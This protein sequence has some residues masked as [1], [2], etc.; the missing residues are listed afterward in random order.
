[1]FLAYEGM[2]MEAEPGLSVT[3]YAAE[4]G[5]PESAFRDDRFTHLRKYGQRRSGTV[6]KRE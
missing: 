2:A 6:D 3:I 1:M 4:P 5:T